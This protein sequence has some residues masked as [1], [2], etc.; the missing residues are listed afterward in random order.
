MSKY[1]TITYVCECGHDR[2][3]K[4]FDRYGITCRRCGKFVDKEEFIHDLDR[5]TGTETE[6]EQDGKN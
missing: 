4:N 6:G 2:W 3:D 5:I 1:E